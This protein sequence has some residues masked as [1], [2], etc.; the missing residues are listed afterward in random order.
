M[1]SEIVG[2]DTYELSTLSMANIKDKFSKTL[3]KYNIFPSWYS[4]PYVYAI[5]KFHKNPVKFRYITSSVKCLGKEPSVILNAVLDK[6]MLKIENESEHNWI[7]KNNQ[8]VLQSLEFCNDVTDL[9]GNHHISTFDFSTLYTTLPHHDL[10]RCIV[11]LFNK[12]IKDEVQITYSNK[13]LKFN[14]VEVVTLLKFCINHNFISFS[15]RIYKQVVGI[16]MGANYSPNLANLYLHFYESKFLSICPSAYS[17]SYKYV[18]RY[19]DDLLVLNNRNVLFDINSMYPKEL[20]ILNTNLAPHKIASFL[21]TEIKIEN[22]K[23]VSKVYDKR[24]DFNFEI[25][26]L[27]SFTS[28]VPGKM[29]Y[30]VLCS[31]FCRFASICTYKE[32]FVHNCQMFI[33]KLQQNGY[34]PNILADFIT[35]FEHNKLMTLM[36]FRFNDKLIENIA[37]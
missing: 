24:R 1:R 26:G 19:I 12:Y 7:I 36:K 18:F 30:G 17:L 11:A 37:I 33:R 21:D 15:D 9:P 14:K 3:Q 27:P 22:G 29:A 8:K 23:F 28:N 2:S 34:P 10:V 20:K 32:D 16:P 13:L 5:P 35:R 31:Q 25:L 4:L 6:L